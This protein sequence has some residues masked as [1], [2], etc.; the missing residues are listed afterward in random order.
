MK[1]RADLHT[2]NPRLHNDEMTRQTIKIREKNY[3]GE[4]ILWVVRAHRWQGRTR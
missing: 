2:N 1:V 3:R 4:E